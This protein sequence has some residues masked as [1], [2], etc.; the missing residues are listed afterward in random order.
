MKLLL[1]G[2]GNM[3]FAMLKTLINYDYEIEVVETNPNRRG[4]LKI[5]YPELK[6]L[7][8]PPEINNYIVLL[9][10]KPQI[11]ERLELKVKLTL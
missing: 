2:A 7:E 11:L 1:I 9:A 5:L 4:E 8:T 6:V 10:I 3:G